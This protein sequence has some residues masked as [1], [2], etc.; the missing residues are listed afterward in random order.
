V[1][2]GALALPLLV[3]ERGAVGPVPIPTTTSGP[4][5][6]PLPA[7]SNDLWRD[8]RGLI[9][10]AIGIVLVAGLV[11][12]YG[13]FVVRANRRT[14]AQSPPSGRPPPKRNPPAKQTPAAKAAPGN[15]TPGTKAVPAQRPAPASDPA[16]TEDTGADRE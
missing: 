6:A 3:A 1:I 2:R 15:R 5:A 12:L 11:A 14:A 7:A 13:W 10:W 8:R 4:A 16:S 9:F